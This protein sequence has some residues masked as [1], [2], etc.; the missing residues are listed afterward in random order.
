MNKSLCLLLI[1]IATSSCT[2]ITPCSIVYPNHDSTGTNIAC[3]QL[4]KNHEEGEKKVKIQNKKQ[5]GQNGHYA[6]LSRSVLVN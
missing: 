1:A 2:V 5:T 6:L 3:V 4:D